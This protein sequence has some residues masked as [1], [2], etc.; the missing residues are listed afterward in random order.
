MIA[1]KVPSVKSLTFEVANF[2]RSNDLGVNTTSGRVKV[3]FTCQRNK[4]KKLAGVVG[5]A[6]VM[7]SCAHCCKKR[8]TRAE[9]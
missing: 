3:D 5:I 6:T 1:L 9:E 8:S 4:W 2:A 7:L